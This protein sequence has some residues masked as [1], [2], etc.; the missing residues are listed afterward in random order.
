MKSNKF[1]EYIELEKKEIENL[2]I[3]FRKKE[4]LYS[5]VNETI[6]RYE[7][8]KISRLNSEIKAIHYEKIIGNYDTSFKKL[9][10]TIKN[11]EAT[12]EMLTFERK[13][14]NFQPRKN[15]WN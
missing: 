9:D 8:N 4:E 12:L 11:V 3:P 6:K 14:S 13:K 2:N 10:K 7:T 5:L 15:T 1:Y